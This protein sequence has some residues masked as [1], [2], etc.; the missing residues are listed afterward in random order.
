MKKTWGIIL[1]ILGA[2]GATYG[3]VE[4]NSWEYQLA[5]GLGVQSSEIT[6]IQCCLYGGIVV[7]VV[8]IILLAIGISKDHQS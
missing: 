5:V 8:G 6:M 1:T 7:L 3:L 2:I 4:T